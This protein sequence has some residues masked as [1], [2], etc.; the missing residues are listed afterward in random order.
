MKTKFLRILG[1]GLTI[2]LLSSLLIMATP[3]SAAT[4]L[5]GSETNVPKT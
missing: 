2:T 5:I 4:L 1:V 3:A